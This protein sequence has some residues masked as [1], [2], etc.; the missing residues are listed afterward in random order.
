M[1]PE[2][3]ELYDRAADPGEARNRAAESPGSVAEMRR[4]L[5]EISMRDRESVVRD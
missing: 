5:E 4:R 1:N 2:D 3:M